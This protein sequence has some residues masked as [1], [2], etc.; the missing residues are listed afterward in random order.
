MVP[1]RLVLILGPSDAEADVEAAA[2]EY[3]ECGELLGE[4]DRLIEGHDQHAR[5]EAD[6]CRRRRDVGERDDGVHDS[7]EGRGPWLTRQGRVLVMGL[8]RVQQAL[9]DPE[10]VVAER[11]RHL[12][13]AHLVFRCGLSAGDGKRKFEFH[14]PSPVET[15]ATRRRRQGGA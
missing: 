9:K 6:A 11:L 4:H 14:W 3:I 10:R 2:R 7:L 12:R 8:E 15:R 5:A 13:H 1:R